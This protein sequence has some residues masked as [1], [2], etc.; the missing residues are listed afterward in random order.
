MIRNVNISGI[1]VGSLVIQA[2]GAVYGF[3]FAFACFFIYGNKFL[4]AALEYPGAIAVTL[5]A[6]LV[7]SFVGGLATMSIAK[8]GLINAFIVGLINLSLNSGFM[9]LTNYVY[10]RDYPLMLIITGLLIIPATMYGGYVYQRK[11]S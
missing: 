7:A 4:V 3:V 2:V 10:A 9:H 11:K 6:T 5:L 1:V 8:T